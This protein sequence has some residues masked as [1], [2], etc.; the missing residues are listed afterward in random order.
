MKVCTVLPLNRPN[1]DML[2]FLVINRTVSNKSIV[3]L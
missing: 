3:G 1:G 2:Y